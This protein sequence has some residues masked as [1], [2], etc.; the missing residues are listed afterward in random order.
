MDSF[1]L[2][3]NKRSQLMRYDTAVILKRFFFV[4]QSLVVSTAG[5]IP[6][7]APLLLKTTYARHLWMDS[8]TAEAMRQR[9]FE[10][11]YPSRL[12]S[13]EGEEPLIQFVDEAR[14]AP[15]AL[16]FYLSLVEVFKP[17]LLSA[18]EQYL[19]LADIIGDGP[20]IRFMELA[21]REKN[22]ELDDLRSFLLPM[23][24]SH[25]GSI[26]AAQ[27]WV[28]ELRQRLAF[29]GGIGLDKVEAEPV[30][31]S[32]MPGRLDFN[33]AQI[34][35]RE[36][37][38][39]RV[40]FYWP[41]I[42]VPDYPYGEG[43]M[44]QLRSAI[45]HINEVW[46]V[47]SCAAFLHAFSDTLGW[48]FVID[49]ARWCY[50]ESRHCQMGYERLK[51]W[52]YQ[53]S[54]IPLGTYIYD[55]AKDTDPIHLLGMLYFFETKN[56]HKKPKRAEKFREYKDNLSEHD[57]D[58]DWADETKHAH[59]GNYWLTKLLEVRGFENDPKIVRQRCNDLVDAII[60]SATEDERRQILAMANA[61]LEKA[62]EAIRQD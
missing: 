47:E 55:A 10:L 9:V 32:L 25:Q 40:R 61:I 17:A 20:S 7:T 2:G 45:S 58:F 60:A 5:W 62:R 38:Y 34:P 16:A 41:D 54:E 44:L 24:A 13:K 42:I 12:M 51:T 56:I 4:E 50:D 1:L 57:M 37:A 26:A 21:K 6:A 46:A 31:I 59:Y 8:L 36:S 53:Q 48:E 3:D 29:M 15:N 27:T 19:K 14:N 52:G 18:Y 39:P 11:R 23:L 22:Q 28:R 49:A 35:A 33:V 30:A 43:L